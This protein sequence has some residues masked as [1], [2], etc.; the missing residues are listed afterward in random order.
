MIKS[1]SIAAFEYNQGLATVKN[2]FTANICLLVQTP[3]SCKVGSTF[4]SSSV[5]AG[6][7]D[8]PDKEDVYGADSTNFQTFKACNQIF[9]LCKLG[10][11]PQLPGILSQVISYFYHCQVT[12][13]L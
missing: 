7:P 12:C 10:D 11:K 1:N 6:S 3:S 8:V 5:F 2:E 4:H 13:V 9:H